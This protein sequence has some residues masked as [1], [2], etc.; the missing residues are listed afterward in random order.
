MKDSTAVITDNTRQIVKIDSTATSTNK[1]IETADL[2]VVFKDTATGFFVLRGDSITIPAQAIKEIRQKRKKQKESDQSTKVTT[3]QAI[4]TD[5]RQKVT[6]KEKAITKDKH[7][8]RISWM[9]I[10]LIIAAVLLYISRKRIYA[11]FKALTI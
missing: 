6:V 8:T 9:W 3:D 1:E 7:V 4:L 11:I 5:T 2:V 10:I